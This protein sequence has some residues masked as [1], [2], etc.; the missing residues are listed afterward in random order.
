MTNYIANMEYAILIFMNEDDTAQCQRAIQLA[1]SGQKQMAYTQFC[2]LLNHDN[3]DNTTLLSW[4]AY[5]TPSLDEAQ[6]AIATIARLEPD[7]PK[8]HF[9]RNY[10]SKKQWRAG[11]QIGPVLRCLHCQHMGPVRI[12]HKVSAVGWV[13]F[14]VSFLLFL[15]FVFITS[16]YMQVV[17]MVEEAL[18]L[19]V[20]S[21]IGL[22]FRKRLHVCASCGSAIGDGKS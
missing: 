1:E 19:L 9:L 6:R 7:H 10:V 2:A 4:I 21:A 14:S 15:Y 16:S 3:A 18:F 20:F 22:F 12:V 17:N 13:W 5:T 8:L 11:V